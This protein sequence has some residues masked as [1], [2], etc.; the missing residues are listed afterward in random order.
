M[1]G[2]GITQGDGSQGGAGREINVRV[3][4]RRVRDLQRAL[5]GR[6][7]AGDLRPKVA[8]TEAVQPNLE[9]RTGGDRRV[10]QVDRGV[11]GAIGAR[12]EHGQLAGQDFI[13]RSRGATVG[14]GDLTDAGLE[15]GAR[16]RHRTREGFRH[17]EVVVVKANLGAR[18][19]IQD[20]A[21]EA[22]DGA[23]QATRLD[24]DGV[25]DVGGGGRTEQV[26][27]TERRRAAGGTDFVEDDVRRT[28]DATAVGR[29]RTRGGLQGQGRVGPDERRSR[30]A[31]DVG[32]VLVETGDIQRRASTEGDRRGVVERRFSVHDQGAAEDLD[33]AG[34]GQ[35]NI[36]GERAIAGFLKLTGATDVTELE[37]QWAVQSGCGRRTQGH[38]RSEVIDGDD[39]AE[40][41]C[42]TGDAVVKDARADLEAGGGGDAKRSASGRLRACLEVPIAEGFFDLDRP[43]GERG[44]D[45][46]KGNRVIGQRDDLRAR[47]DA[48]AAHGLAN[49]KANGAADV[50]QGAEGGLRGGR[51]RDG[52]AER[53]TRGE[54]NYAERFRRAKHA[55]KV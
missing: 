12:V 13:S 33:R 49:R 53:R 38:R 30:I 11:A 37:G 1:E 10:D 22:S 9:R 40:E 3:V 39:G 47:L 15:D 45:R 2:D 16:A 51:A 48:R 43:R 26:E 23:D 17:G 32:Q 44:G 36:Q 4:V 5:R 34:Q 20:R 42:I 55:R 14:E 50:D 52:V 6:A 41:T 28:G 31:R 18:R 54:L 29:G 25:D 19:D 8:L 7:E 46:I 35:G 24:I 21:T 27:R